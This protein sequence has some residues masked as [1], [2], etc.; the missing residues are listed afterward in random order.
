M[1]RDPKRPEAATAKPERPA[2]A[3]Y[4][5]PRILSKRS[6]ERVTQQLFSGGANPGAP[7]GPF[8]GLGG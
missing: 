8:G 7:G 5:P 1:I 2:A 4:E 3:P 6:L